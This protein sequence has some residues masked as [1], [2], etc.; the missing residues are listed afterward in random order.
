MKNHVLSPS[1]ILSVVLVGDKRS[2]DLNFKYRGK[3]GPTDI[4]SFKLTSNEGELFFNL[5]EVKKHARTA[6]RSFENFLAFLF[7][8]G[9]LHLKGL[10]HGSKMESKE[11]QVRKKFGIDT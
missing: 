10:T 8:H 6:G 11:K 3:R 9:L 2:A 5:T 1:Y 4:L 7:I